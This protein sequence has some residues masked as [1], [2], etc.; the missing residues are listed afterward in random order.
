MDPSPLLIYLIGFYRIV[1]NSLEN[2]EE[3]FA[4]NLVFIKVR[5]DSKIIAMYFADIALSEY[6]KN[7][8]K[9]GISD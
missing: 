3:G 8:F 7:L 2:D 6:L 5:G 9:R 1:F 4:S